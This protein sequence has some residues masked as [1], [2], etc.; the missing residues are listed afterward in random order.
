MPLQSHGYN[1]PAKFLGFSSY[2]P[3]RGIQLQATISD[4]SAGHDISSHNLESIAEEIAESD[5]ND[6]ELP[7]CEL[8]AERDPDVTQLSDHLSH[9]GESSE[10][11]LASALTNCSTCMHCLK[12]LTDSKSACSEGGRV[13]NANIGMRDER[14]Y[15]VLALAARHGVRDIVL[16]LLHRGANPN[17]RSYQGTGVLAHTVV[18]LSRAQK[19]QD[20]RL[21]ARILSCL[22]VL[23]DHGAK[24]KPS[25]YDEFSVHIPSCDGLGVNTGCKRLS[26]EE[27]LTGGD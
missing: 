12:L 3:C 18:H 14:G 25:V 15:T 13:Q 23:T 2:S 20:D 1:M 6:E 8:D 11:Q 19:T 10:E 16:Q 4:L 26:R 5:A 21:Y 9:T 22:V 7:S 24:P 27:G 17:T